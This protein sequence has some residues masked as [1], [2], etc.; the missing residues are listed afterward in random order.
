[1]LVQRVHQAFFLN[2]V[3]SKSSLLKI[4]S[5]KAW[6]LSIDTLWTIVQQSLVALSAHDSVALWR[7]MRTG[8]GS[9][10]AKGVDPVIAI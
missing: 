9:L 4:G 8:A 7:H 3:L 1:M 10:F 6:R 2:C 5:V